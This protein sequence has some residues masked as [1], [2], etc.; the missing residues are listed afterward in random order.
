M[1][2]YSV[3][4]NHLLLHLVVI[5]FGFTGIL[6]KLIHIDPVTLVWYRMILGCVSLAV[7][8]MF[9]KHTINIPLKKALQ[10]I[11]SGMIIACHWIGF[12]W[13]INVSNVSVTLATLSATALF[14]AFLNPLIRRKKVKIYEFLLA[15]CI[16]VGLLFIYNVNASY[17]KGIMIALAAA[18]LASLFTVLNGKFIETDNAKTISFY[19]LLGGVIGIS[20]YM[21]FFQHSPTFSQISNMSWIYILILGTICTGFTFVASTT[22]MKTIS[23]FSVSMTV[24]LEPVYG[25]IMAFLIFGQSEVMNPTFYIGAG[26]ILISL[27]VNAALKNKEKK[28]FIAR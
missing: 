16:I 4:N 7:Y 20:L 19:E 11:F 23:P 15:V 2:K 3:A 6:G 12:F 28:R 13:A 25:I 21:V 18:G 26:I 27:F 17:H 5:I 8:L 24:N 14:T 9:T 1:K 22:V 10:F